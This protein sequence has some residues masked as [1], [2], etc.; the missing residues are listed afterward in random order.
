VF[1]EWGKMIG[2]IRR[3]SGMRGRLAAAFGPP[4]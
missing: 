3:A 4:A 2:G 1:G